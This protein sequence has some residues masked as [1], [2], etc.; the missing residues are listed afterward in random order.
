MA[1]I[2]SRAPAHAALDPWVRTIWSYASTP[3]EPAYE[4]VMPSSGGQLLVNLH[5]DE[6][7]HWS[8][9]GEL[10]RR[11]GAVGVQGALTRPIL[12]DT[13]QKQAVCGVAF[14]SGGLTAF[15]DLPATELT[16]ALV[17]GRELWPEDAAPLRSALAAESDPD[18]RIER[19]EAFLLDQLRERTDE[20]ARLREL[21]DRI[22]AGEA[23]EATRLAAGLSQ[24]AL[25][26]LFE[27]RIGLR[28]KRFARIE[29]FAA[30]LD[31]APDR[32]SWAELAL[33][34]GFSDQAHLS[35]EYASL[36]GASPTGHRPV[37]REP[38]HAHLD[39]GAGE[40]AAEE[41]FKNEEDR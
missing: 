15:C 38:R 34:M 33:S 35:R 39:P 5:E 24:R 7:R 3:G 6:L 28:P 30:A 13:A 17:D 40:D 10:A 11:I 37:E 36:A 16:D 2:R 20:D 25:H 29:R 1:T 12:I 41:S 9:P 32:S 26:A 19:I 22:A 27:R 18:R 4:Q 14:R 31:A 23:I 21:A 8:A